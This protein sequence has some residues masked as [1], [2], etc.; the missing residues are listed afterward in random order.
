MKKFLNC[1][2]LT[3]SL[4]FLMNHV[5][6][7]SVSKNDVTIQSGNNTSVEL[8][9]NSEASVVSVT[10]TLVYSTY[11]IP[12]NFSPVAGVS[13]T[14]PNGITHEL[15]LDE[16]KSGKILLGNVNI[17][18]VANPNDMVG[19][20]N[21]HSASAKTTDGETINLNAQN[22]NIKVGTTQEEPK[23]DEPKKEE[24]KKELDKNLLD[25]IESKLVK[26]NLKKDTFE[27]EV[28]IKENVE[29]LDLKPVAKDNNTKVEISTQKI[30]DLKDNKITITAKNDDVEQKYIINV[31][32]DAENDTT[33]NHA[34]IDNEIFV[35]NK[36]YKGK[37]A[38]MIA[39]FAVALIVS[40]IFTKKK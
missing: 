1:F 37:W 28:T 21:I 35:E 8:Y 26:I 13:D 38:I 4:F 27:Y 36:S 30:K 25:K 34:T 32:V 14:N 10:F 33:I 9:A 23:Q 6:A 40:L 24:P 39:F 2:V 16:A 22:I 11:D 5:D 31:K 3:I 18:V 29:E 19:T 7:L 17:N 15:V 20:V 12:A